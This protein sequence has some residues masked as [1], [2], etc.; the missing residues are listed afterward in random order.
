MS[1]LP[2]KPHDSPALLDARGITMDYPG[3]RALDKASFSLREGEIHALLGE[4]GAGKSTLVKIFSGLCS[5]TAGMV[6]LAGKTFAPSHARDAQA[7]GVST[8]FQEVDVLPLMSVADN[9]CLNRQNTRLGLFRRSQ[10]RQRA[11]AALSRLDLNLDLSRSLGEFPIAIQQMVSIARVLDIDARVLILDEP[12]SSLDAREA[13]ELFLVM[14]RLKASGMGIIFISHFLEHVYGIC[15][16]ITVLRNGSTVGEWNAADLSKTALIQAMTGR[17]ITHA[18]RAPNAGVAATSDPVLKVNGFSRRRALEPTSIHVHSGE[19]LGLAGLLGSGRTE[20]ARLIFGADKPD[21]GTVSM[22][23]IQLSPGNIPEA[24]SHGIA[25]TPEDRKAQGLILDLSV[26]ENIVLAVQAQRGSLNPLSFAEQTA[27]ANH[28]IAS[29][30]IKTPSPET[31]VKGLSGGNQQ[32][33]LLARWLAIQPKVLILDE[34]TRGVDVGA[35]AEIE[36]L[37]ESQRQKGLAII[38]ISSEFEE[39]VRTCTRVTVMRDKIAI[40]ELSS[41]IS[42]SAILAVIAQGSRA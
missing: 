26:R 16:R 5:P 40:A 33:V 36:A 34:P 9:I 37:I 12:T 28:Y 10:V 31:P 32:K 29:M 11:K 39:L 15:D 27:L 8:V 30:S 3:V 6:T 7:A 22:N 23:S 24:I 4:N 19:S 18:A 21:G 35:R 20:L 1:E 17:T 25:F 2:G 41:D 14:R 38:F 42:E 13:N